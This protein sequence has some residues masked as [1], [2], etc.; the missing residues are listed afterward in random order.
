M[1]ERIATFIQYNNL[2]LHPLLDTK[3]E[4][5]LSVSEVAQAFKVDINTIL[6]IAASKESALIKGRHYQSEEILSA[7]IRSSEVLLWSKKGILRLAYYLKSDAALEFLDFAEDL[8]LHSGQGVDT[9]SLHMYDEVEE[10]LLTRLKQLK[11]DKNMSLE[12]L[13][14]LI[15][16]VDNLATKKAALNTEKQESA[17]LD[18]ILSGV[19]QMLQIDPKN[20]QSGMGGFLKKA[21]Q[22]RAAPVNP[23]PV[24]PTKDPFESMKPLKK[25]DVPVSEENN[26]KE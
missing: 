18:S 15:Y 6:E 2:E 26:S 11:E 14:K 22:E 9:H 4:W 24:Q 5:F 20:M 8:D 23:Q 25:F 1:A 7:G 16:T 13:N 3:H 17:P 10:N 21:M 19:M 12:E